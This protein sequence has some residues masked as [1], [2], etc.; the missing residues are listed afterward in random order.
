MTDSR[1]RPRPITIGTPAIRFRAAAVTL[2]L[3]LSGCRKIEQAPATL[4]DVLLGLWS[5][6]DD[7]SAND[8]GQLA[9]DMAN[10]LDEDAIAAQWEKGT[11]APMTAAAQ[12]AADLHAP[13]DDDGTW[14]LPDPAEATPMYLA[15][16]F[17]CAPD[18]LADILVALN[19]DELYPGNYDEYDRSYLDSIDDFQSGA[20]DRVSWSVDLTKTVFGYPQY[21]ETLQGGLRRVPVPT[22]L[23]SPPGWS[24]EDMLVA[25]TWIPYPAHVVDPDKADAFRFDQDYQIEA[26]L[27]WA[28]GEVVHL[29]GL[30]RQLDGSLGTLENVTIQQFMLNALSDWDKDTARLCADGLP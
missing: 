7:A 8:Y 30:W 20:S 13:P 10:V 18:A 11:Q 14:A 4:S 27:P 3:L 1:R 23:D 25:R 22:G 17:A 16:R 6:W 29:Y 26:Y 5:G 21:F 2:A 12:A 15:K 9:L 19:Q 28:N 24:G